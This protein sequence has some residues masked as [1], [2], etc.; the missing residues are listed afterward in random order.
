[1]HILASTTQ[2]LAAG[3][4]LGSFTVQSVEPMSDLQTTQI[5]L[6]G[7]LTLSGVLSFSEN[8]FCLV[9]DDE[10]ALPLPVPSDGYVCFTNPEAFATVG[11]IGRWRITATIGDVVLRLSPERNSAE[12]K[13]VDLA[14]YERI[15]EE[16]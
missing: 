8:R 11:T 13:L 1:M 16:E 12:A 2:T 14:T 9:P 6:N 5:R 4:P 3:Q 10:A 7:T 15:P